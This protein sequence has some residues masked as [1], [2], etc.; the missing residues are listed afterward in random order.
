MKQLLPILA[1][2][3][4]L[5]FLVETA[6]A[7]SSLEISN[8]SDFSILSTNFNGGETI[9]AR[10]ETGNDGN[11]L[12]VLNVRDNNYS[13]LNSY[14]LNKEG[15]YF[16]ATLSTPSQAGFYSLEARIESADSTTTSVKTIKVGSPTNASL[17]VNVNS[18][19]E[20]NKTDSESDS[21]L[22]S[23]SPAR[24]VENLETSDDLRNNSDYDYEQNVGKKGFTQNMILI[25]RFVLDFLWPF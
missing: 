22:R 2:M 21:N 19:L 4:T 17:K 25:A 9:Y 14:I 10:V 5:S 1:V 24:K 23:P 16:T 18:R 13:V 3:F 6:L 11:D 8:T 12:R 20:G 7:S 15:N